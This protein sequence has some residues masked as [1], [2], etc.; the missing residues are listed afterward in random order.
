MD[1]H[2]PYTSNCVGHANY[3]TFLVFLVYCNAALVHSLALIIAHFLHLLSTARQQQVIRTGGIHADYTML[4]VGLQIVAFLIALPL[5]VG[6]MLLL[7]WHVQLVLSNKTT[8]EYRE[9]V[10]AKMQGLILH[11]H[12]Y[13]LGAYHNLNQILGEDHGLWACPPCAPTSGGT[14]FVAVFDMHAKGLTP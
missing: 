7:G 1:H 9:G 12:P 6:L 3:R 8:I 13:D 5:S 11:E 14:S 2:C 4:W 10:T